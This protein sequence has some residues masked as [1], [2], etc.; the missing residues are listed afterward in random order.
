MTETTG[1]GAVY[2]PKAPLLTDKEMEAFLTDGLT[3]EE[4]VIE[5]ALSRPRPML[6][7]TLT[8]VF[9]LLPLIFGSG[10]GSEVQRPL[11][12][13]VVGGLCSSTLLTLV[14]LPTLYWHVEIGT[15]AFRPWFPIL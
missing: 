11:A 10:V 6:M 9:G 15:F 14:V 8:T 4:V 3:V 13:V 1:A 5:D 7:A 2:D 12:T